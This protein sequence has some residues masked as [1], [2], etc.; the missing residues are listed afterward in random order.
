MATR[1]PLTQAERHYIQTRKRA[2]VSLRQIATELQCAYA[3]VCKWWR[4]IRQNRPRPARGRPRQGI[5]STYP[6]ALVTQA[7]A[8]KRDHPHWGPP[9]VKL[10]LRRQPAWQTAQLPS[11]ARLAALFKA[12]CPEAVQPRRQRQYPD[13]P[14]PAVRYPHQRWQIDAKEHVLVGDQEIVTMLDV[15]DVAA[16]LMIASRAFVTTT[17]KG[18]RKLTLPEVQDT[19]RAA[20]TEWGLPLEIQTDHEVVYTGAPKADFP[21]QFTLW[22]VGLGIRHIPSRD[23]RPTDQGHIERNHRT[24]AEMSW[25]DSHFADVAQLQA[26]AEEGRMRYN[27]ELPVHAADCQG[28][29]P[30]VAHPNARHSG[31]PFTRALEWTLFEIAR[32][33][34]C[35]SAQ[36]WTRQVSESG[37]VSLGHHLYAVGRSY[38]HQ[39]VSVHFRGATRSFCF[40]HSDGRVLAEHA[41][42][43]LD[44]ADLIGFMP[45]E[46]AI[47]IGWQLPLPLE[48][49]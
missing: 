49:V 12:A 18:W 9:N 29:P 44:K 40:Q 26:A 24:L 46:A 28:Q 3:T 48:G 4:C 36:L 45:C 15:R 17:T 8:I 25:A 32:V 16:A 1:A 42:V 37:N 13:R 7:I 19:L 33:D 41:A 34:G 27:Q 2:G 31:R 14:P 47:P 23:R 11:D 21:S 20:F 10:E 30:L 6:A 38:A 22:L 39:T 5:L 43:G 35:L